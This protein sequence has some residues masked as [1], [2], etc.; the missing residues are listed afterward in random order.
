[1]TPAVHP[2]SR[3]PRVAQREEDE[4][5]FEVRA[6][7]RRGEAHGL[8]RELAGALELLHHR[9]ELDP[10]RR[11]VEATDA[12]VDRVDLAPPDDAHELVAG[13]LELQ[14]SLDDLAVIARHLEAVGVP[15]EVRRVQHEDVQRVA[16][17]P[18]AAIEHPPQHAHL[19]G[20]VDAADVLHR[21]DRA[22]LVGD[23]ADATYSGGDVWNLGEA[24]PRR[25][26]SKK[27]GGS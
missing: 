11:A 6:R 5:L 10:R 17:D 25:N 8:D 7:Q 27:R 16:L 23:R 14:R 15:E 12:D 4:V 1:L 9:R 24:P 20:H 22:H 3:T 18:L 2:R 13:L 21:P 19:V 26:A